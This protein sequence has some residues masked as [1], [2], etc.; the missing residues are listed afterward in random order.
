M[1]SDLAR[2]LAALCQAARRRS[3]DRPEL[4][5]AFVRGLLVRGP[6]A[7]EAVRERLAQA[8][9]PETRW[10]TVAAAVAEPV[11]APPPPL[12]TRIATRARA[13]FLERHGVQAWFR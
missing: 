9:I 3:I 10:R 4:L 11:P 2:D 7:P 12:V 1:S 5:L 8:S 6:I 13:A